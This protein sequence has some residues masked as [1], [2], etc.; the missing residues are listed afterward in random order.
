MNVGPAASSDGVADAWNEHA[1]KVLSLSALTIVTVA[2]VAYHYLEDWSWVDSLYFSVVAV[3]TVGFGDLTPT[4]DAAKLFTVAY[5][6]VGLAIIGLY[7]NVRVDRNR[8]RRLARARRREK[9][10]EHDEPD[11]DGGAP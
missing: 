1:Y 4:T 7:L 8:R 11:N 9:G 3:T 2:T 6:L 5:I 10:N